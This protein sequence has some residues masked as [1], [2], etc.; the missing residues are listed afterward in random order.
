MQN[1]RD[2]GRKTRLPGLRRSL[3][4]RIAVLRLA[5]YYVT[6]TQATCTCLNVLHNCLSAVFAERASRS[7]TA[8]IQVVDL[9]TAF[10]NDPFIDEKVRRNYVAHHARIFQQVYKI[11]RVNISVDAA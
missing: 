8:N 5:L 6:C 11:E 9:G 2:E 7:L 3:R 4:L 10:T 1:L